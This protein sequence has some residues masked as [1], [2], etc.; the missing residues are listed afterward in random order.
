MMTEQEKALD[1]ALCN[2]CNNADDPL[3]S[4]SKWDEYVKRD[5]A[6]LCAAYNEWYMSKMQSTD[7]MPSEVEPS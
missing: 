6:V 5:F 7:T 3:P 1:A 2:F 4:V